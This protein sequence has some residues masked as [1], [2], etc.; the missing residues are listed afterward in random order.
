[1][2]Q[3]GILNCPEFIK[4]TMEIRCTVIGGSP[5]DCAVEIEPG[6][7]FADLI[8]AVGYSPQ[9]ATAIV[10]NKPVPD[11]REVRS[12]DVKILRLIQGG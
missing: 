3:S 9:E 4:F 5:R 7:T 1:M 12:T 10:D 2:R 8:Q 6:D 11:D